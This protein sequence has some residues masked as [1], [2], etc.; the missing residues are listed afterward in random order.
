MIGIKRVPEID[1][2][3][4]DEAHK[5]GSKGKIGGAFLFQSNL[6]K[7]IASI[8]GNKR[9]ISYGVA[10]LVAPFS[11]SNAVNIIRAGE[12]LS[13]SKTQKIMEAGLVAKQAE[14]DPLDL[15]GGRS[16]QQAADLAAAQKAD[17]EAQQQEQKAQAQEAIQVQRDIAAEEKRARDE[18]LAAA[19][20][21]ADIQAAEAKRQTKIEEAGAQRE[22]VKSVR[23]RR[24]SGG[25]GSLL[26]GS[27]KGVS[28][29]TGITKTAVA[30]NTTDSL[31]ST[32]G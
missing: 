9:A 23:R 12:E 8:A 27:E 28:S 18:Q 14:M 13:T 32:L 29:R 31:A 6:N 22:R 4:I 15:F 1:G 30:T 11:P 24:R 25:G 5:G 21:E 20:R 17:A 2:L 26:S 16:T 3:R 10:P 7:M 19:K